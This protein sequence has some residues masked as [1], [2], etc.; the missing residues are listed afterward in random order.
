MWWKQMRFEM[1]GEVGRDGRLGGDKTRR[2]ACCVVYLIPVIA[3]RFT[4]LLI[5]MYMYTKQIHSTNA[6]T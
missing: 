3:L 4:Q 6:T 1:K 5:T 2:H